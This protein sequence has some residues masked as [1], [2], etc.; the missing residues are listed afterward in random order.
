MCRPRGTAS[1]PVHPA[2]SPAPIIGIGRFVH[3]EAFHDKFLAPY[4]RS[5]AVQNPSIGPIWVTVMGVENTGADQATVTFCTDL[6]HWH[7]A[8]DGPPDARGPGR[9]SSRT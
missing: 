5:S 7:A 3:L 4:E 1:A 6:G 9:T 8:E 2:R